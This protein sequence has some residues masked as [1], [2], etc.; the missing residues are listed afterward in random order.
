MQAL[1]GELGLEQPSLSARGVGRDQVA[2]IAGR[3]SGGEPSDEVLALVE[4]L[5]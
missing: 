4:S 1:V 2:V 5:F 3:A